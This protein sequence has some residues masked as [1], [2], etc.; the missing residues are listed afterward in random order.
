MVTRL[1]SGLLALVLWVSLS[2][3]ALAGMPSVSLTNMGRMRLEVISFFTVL[4]LLSTLLILLLWNMLAKDFKWLPR[5]TFF[6]ALLVTILW[7]LLFVFVLTMIAGA[8]ELLQPGAWERTG[9]L[10][11]LSDD[12]K[13]ENEDARQAQARLLDRRTDAM[14]DLRA[15]LFSY[16]AAND[17]LFLPSTE[18]P[19]ITPAILEIPNAHGA[20]YIYRPHHKQ[21][22]DPPAII[23]FEPEIFGNGRVV[24]YSDGRVELLA[25]SEFLKIIENQVEPTDPQ[26]ET[27]AAEET[28]TEDTPTVD[29][30]TVEEP[31]VEETPSPEA[32]SAETETR[33]EE[34]L[35][36]DSTEADS[37]ETKPA[38]TDMAEPVMADSGSEM[39]Q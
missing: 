7:G 14:R 35:A 28:N 2:T 13:V 16:A 39:D 15:V 4:L 19:G 9:A 3:S 17:G 33:E 18:V 24:L 29:D 38:V 22:D 30:T 20:Q 10:Y 37:G 11:K 5:L 21:S 27:P 34:T 1:W 32:E 26:T 25:E 8:R 31:A 36:V 23:A 12:D 6:R